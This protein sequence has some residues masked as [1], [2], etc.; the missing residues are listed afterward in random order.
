MNIKL[1]PHKEFKKAIVRRS[2]KGRITYNYYALIEVCEKIYE[3]S[4]EDAVEWVDYNILGLA[5]MGFGVDYKQDWITAGVA[6]PE[7]R[8]GRSKRSRRSKPGR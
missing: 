8:P 6:Q 2:K 3:L 4:A 1:E 5:P 7:D